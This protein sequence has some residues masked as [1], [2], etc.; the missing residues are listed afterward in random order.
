M[1]DDLRPAG[2]DDLRL[3]VERLAAAPLRGGGARADVLAALWALELAASLSSALTTRAA[4]T[5]LSAG[6]VARLS[7][8][9]IRL[10]VAASGAARW[11]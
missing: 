11:L 5:S 1:A 8:S 3:L 7:D 6:D 9:L 10:S 2:N 4:V